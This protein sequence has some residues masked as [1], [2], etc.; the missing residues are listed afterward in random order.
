MYERIKP[1]DCSKEDLEA[2]RQLK[3]R[4]A[5]AADYRKQVQEQ[6]QRISEMEKAKREQMRQGA[7]VI[8]TANNDILRQQVNYLTS[9][10]DEEIAAYADKLERLADSPHPVQGLYDSHGRPLV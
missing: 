6:N 8:R 10:T 3:A 7:Q 9:L 5:D 2:L 4:E 1:P